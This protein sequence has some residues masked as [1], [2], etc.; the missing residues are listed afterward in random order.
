MPS[1]GHKLDLSRKTLLL[2]IS[3]KNPHQLCII[4]SISQMK[5]QRLNNMPRVSE[6]TMTQQLSPALLKLNLMSFSL[7]KVAF[8]RTNVYPHLAQVKLAKAGDTNLDL[9]YRSALKS[10]SSLV[11]ALF[12]RRLKISPLLFR[13]NSSLA[14]LKAHQIHNLLFV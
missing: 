4:S 6:T 11:S 3:L 9:G 1:S 7:H 10:L 2:S 5:K 13:L 14:R 12:F 8:K